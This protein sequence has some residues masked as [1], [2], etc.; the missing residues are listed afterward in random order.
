[1]HKFGHFYLPEGRALAVS[2][3]NY[4]N[5]RRYT[6]AAVKAVI[7]VINPALFDTLLPVQL[8]PT[9]SHVELA[10]AFAR[11]VTSRE[12]YVYDNGKLVSG[13]PFSSQPDALVAIGESKRSS[14]VKRNIDT[15]KAFKS[16]FTFYS[17]PKADRSH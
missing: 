11:L 7:P 17:A 4:I 3:A 15:G 16:R 9:M 14:A 2:I 1:M 12:I 13:S 10:Q 5:G 8:T 6:S